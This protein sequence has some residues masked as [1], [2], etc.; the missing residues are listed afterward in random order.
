MRLVSYA[1]AA[2]LSL[3][4][5][6]AIVA[7]FETSGSNTAKVLGTTVEAFIYICSLLAAASL[8]LRQARL[9]LAVATAVAATSAF[10][11]A[12]VTTWS[13]A[14]SKDLVKATFAWLVVG[15]AATYAAVVL[16]RVRPT[17]A[18]SVWAMVAGA[19]VFDAALATLLV[20]AIL[21]NVQDSTFYRWVGVAFVLLTVSTAVLPFVRRFDV[22][23]H[24]RET[25]SREAAR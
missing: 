22:R 5:V 7:I 19:L 14:P 24:L 25:T 15:L 1:L 2:V 3:A 21:A 16:S 10:V 18:V 8:P 17:D 6:V 11:L 20:V 13:S 9:V 12:V 4:A 23:E